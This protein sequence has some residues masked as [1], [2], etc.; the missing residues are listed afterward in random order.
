MV[1]TR[2]ISSTEI[3]RHQCDAWNSRAVDHTIDLLC[4]DYQ[5]CRR[6]NSLTEVAGKTRWASAL[7]CVWTAGVFCS[8]A[9][10]TVIAIAV[11]TAT[12]DTATAARIPSLTLRIYASHADE[13]QSEEKQ[14][15]HYGCG[16]PE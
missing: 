13:Q 11:K 4:L 7:V 6:N 12:P 3:G 1:V 16:Q 15:P 10:S 9:E 2:V 5:R 8:P 14:E